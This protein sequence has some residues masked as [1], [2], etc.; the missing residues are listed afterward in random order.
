MADTNLI[1]AHLDHRRSYKNFHYVYPVIS[2]RSQG[3]SIGINLNPDKK[4]DFN[5]IYCEVDRVSPARCHDV[6]IPVLTKELRKMLRIYQDG[7]LF[8]DEPFAGVPSSLRRLNDIAFSGDGEPTTCPVFERAVEAVW[9]VRE[10][11]G[12]DTTKLVLITNG[13]CLDRDGVRQGICRIQAGRNEIWAKLDAGTPEYYHLVNR[14]HVPYVWILKNIAEVARWCPVI[15]QSL[16]L[17]VAGKPPDEREIGAYAARLNEIW[18]QGGK[19]L[20]VQLYTMARRAATSLATPLSNEELNRIA[21]QVEE[22][23]GLPYTL[24]YGHA[25]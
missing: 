3:V 1:A 16:F 23:T 7:T 4:C 6:D 13:S 10:D 18:A 9:R 24:Y 20:G 25:P 15:I 19:I 5:C 21:A 12:L 2:R 11:L 22:L 17:R 14:S 8:E